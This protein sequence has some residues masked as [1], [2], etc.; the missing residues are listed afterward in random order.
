MAKRSDR[1]LKVEAVIDDIL[2][3]WPDNFTISPFLVRGLVEKFFE[4]HL[5]LHWLRE[6]FNARGIETLAGSR[7]LVNGYVKKP[8]GWLREGDFGG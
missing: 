8:W 5:Q 2:I 1:I 6:T 4:E 7:L 3:D